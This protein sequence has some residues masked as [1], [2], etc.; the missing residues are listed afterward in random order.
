MRTGEASYFQR[1]TQPRA[2]T[3]NA[4]P[5]SSIA[6]SWAPKFST[7]ELPSANRYSPTSFGPWK[8]VFSGLS[9]SARI[10]SRSCPLRPSSDLGSP[11]TRRIRHVAR[12][13]DLRV[14]LFRQTL[15]EQRRP[16]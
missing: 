3:L 9:I 1:A 6:A 7:T 13:Q 11:F 4:A 10:E 2:G 8:V 12:L 16:P 15:G 5:F 14:E